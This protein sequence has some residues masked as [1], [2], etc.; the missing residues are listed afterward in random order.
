LT[1]PSIETLGNPA[2]AKELAKLASSTMAALADKYPYRFVG[3][4]ASLPMN[5][6]SAVSPAYV[7]L[8]APAS[9][10]AMVRRT[11]VASL[12]QPGKLPPEK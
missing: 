6:W 10:P 2:A 1:T 7:A 12:R 8:L 3:F 4:V 11:S 9:T 5:M